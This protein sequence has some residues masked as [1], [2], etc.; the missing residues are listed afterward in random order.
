MPTSGTASARLFLALWP[1][2]DTLAQLVARRD[3]IQ[4]EAGASVSK[5]DRL[6]LTLSFI[7]QVPRDRIGALT[8]T[9]RVPAGEIELS[10]TWLDVW[11]DD[12]AVLRPKEIPDSLSQLQLALAAQL[13]KAGMPVEEREFRPHVTLARNAG[14]TV[15]VG[16]KPVR[17]RSREYVLAESRSGYH[18]VERYS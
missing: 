17:W 8:D 1:A 11:N 9:L 13:R 12:I 14:A 10:L 3:A 2:A 4:W 7:G 18:V 5:D 6:H 15:E 16:G